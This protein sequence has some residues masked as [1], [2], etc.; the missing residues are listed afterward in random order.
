MLREFLASVPSEGSAELF[1]ESCHLGGER[2][3][4]R[5]CSITGKRRPVLDGVL[6]SIALFS[7]L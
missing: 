7:E 6:V 3:F 4:H 5:D 2:V 1:G